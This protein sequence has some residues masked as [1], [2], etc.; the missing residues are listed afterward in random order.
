MHAQ[1]NIDDINVVAYLGF[2][3][4]INHPPKHMYGYESHL[5]ILHT[6]AA[7][8]CKHKCTPINSNP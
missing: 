2:H 8:I 3:Q 1:S 6:K 7:H 4:N 5:G